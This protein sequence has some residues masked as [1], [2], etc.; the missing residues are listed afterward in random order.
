MLHFG[1]YVFSLPI[2]HLMILKL[3]V[4]HRMI[5]ITNWGIWVISRCLWFGHKM[6]Y[7]VNLWMDQLSRWRLYRLMVPGV[8]IRPGD[9]WLCDPYFHMPI[10]WSTKAVRWQLASDSK[11]HGDNMGPIWG[12]QDSRG[13][14]VGSINLAIGGAAH[15]NYIYTQWYYIAAQ[16]KDSIPFGSW[17]FSAY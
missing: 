7:A 11:V 6:A 12:Q 3:L 9:I 2:F 10:D 8:L 15:G 14:H 1:L 16:W 13:P 4:L 17:P 5:R